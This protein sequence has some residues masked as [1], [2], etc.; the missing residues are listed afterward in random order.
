MPTRCSTSG[1]AFSGARVGL[2]QQADAAL[3]AHRFLRCS[4]GRL[5]RDRNGQHD[6]REQHGLAHGQ[7]NQYV[8]AGHSYGF[9]RSGATADSRDPSCARSGRSGPAATQCA[10]ACGHREFPAARYSRRRSKQGAIPS[11]RSASRP[12]L[13]ARS[14]H[15]RAHQAR[16]PPHARGSHPRKYRSAVPKRA[17]W[18]RRSGQRNADACA[19]P[20]RAARRPLPTSRSFDG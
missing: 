9:P 16:P 11:R 5:A 19:R 18:G 8:F 12:G 20:V 15:R 6:A 4:E 13:A 17:G 2:Q 10:G 14:P 1:V 3:G 7:D